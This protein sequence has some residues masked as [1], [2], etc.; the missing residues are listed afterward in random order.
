[1]QCALFE[2]DLYTYRIF[3]TNL[4]AKAHKVIVQHDKRADVKNLI[5]ESKSEDLDAISSAKSKNSYVFLQIVL[6]V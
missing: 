4:K 2:D 3:C 6:I 1:M 5:G